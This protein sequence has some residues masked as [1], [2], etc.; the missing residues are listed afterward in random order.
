MGHVINGIC[1][2]RKQIAVHPCVQGLCFDYYFCVIPPPVY[3]FSS[4]F[5]EVFIFGCLCFFGVAASPYPPLVRCFF[6]SRTPATRSL[7]PEINVIFMTAATARHGVLYTDSNGKKAPGSGGATSVVTEDDE[8]IRPVLKEAK[9]DERQ[10]LQH[11][12]KARK[13]SQ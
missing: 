13:S 7:T 4:I 6:I 2:D 3:F 9:K 1:P 10:D 5:L 8:S 12:P 11:S